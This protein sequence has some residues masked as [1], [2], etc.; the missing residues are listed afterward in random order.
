MLWRPLRIYALGPYL[1][2]AW[3]IGQRVGEASIL[4]LNPGPGERL[5]GLRLIDDNVD[6]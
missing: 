5:G 4:V 1:I 6:F 3:S 2:Q